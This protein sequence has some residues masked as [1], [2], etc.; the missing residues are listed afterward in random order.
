MGHSIT[1]A[2]VLS[3]FVFIWR[4]RWD[5]ML[6][7]AH[8]LLSASCLLCSHYDVKGRATLAPPEKTSLWPRVEP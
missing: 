7:P 2:M 6:S 4:L 3:S 5:Y 1:A 8:V